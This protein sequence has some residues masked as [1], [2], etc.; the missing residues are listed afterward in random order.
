MAFVFGS[1]D[2][3]TNCYVKNIPLYWTTEQ[4]HDIFEKFGASE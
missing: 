3:W 1:N 2:V 4:L